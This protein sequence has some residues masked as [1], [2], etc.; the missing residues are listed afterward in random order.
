MTKQEIEA[1][2]DSG[3]LEVQWHSGKW[4]AVRRNGVTKLWKRDQE[5]FA[6]PCKTGF[7]ECFTIAYYKGDCQPSGGYTLDSPYLRI[8]SGEPI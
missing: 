7:R 2:L 5:R 6:I 4:Y 3:K 8:A 1:A